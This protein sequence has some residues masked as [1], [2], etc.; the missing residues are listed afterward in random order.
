MKIHFLTMKKLLILLE[1]S[2]EILIF[3]NRF[4]KNLPM[5]SMIQNWTKKTES[6][7]IKKKLPI[8][9]IMIGDNFIKLPF[10]ALANTIVED[11]LKNEVLK[12]WLNDAYCFDFLV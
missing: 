9:K 4:I 12:V 11:S 1:C 7:W 10:S 8:Q 5:G 2:K 6:F 3:R